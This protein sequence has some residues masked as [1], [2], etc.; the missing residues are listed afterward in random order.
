MGKA[1]PV[2]RSLKFENTEAMLGEAKSLLET[3]YQSHGNW[4]L[5][6]TCGHIANWMQYPL[7]GFPRP[8]IPLRL[9]L[10][11]VKHTFGP[12]M[13]R[14]ILAEGFSGGSPTAPQA[15]PAA[16]QISD[17]QGFEKLQQAVDRLTAYDGPILPSPLFGPMDKSTL[18]KITLLHA[19]HHLG[20]LEPKP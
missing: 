9:I 13:K 15:V 6:Q 4:T 8:P 1:A 17:Q 12:G 20:Y 18:L 16:D 7:D 10:W 5:G 14:K 11:A 2:K 3:G 19:E